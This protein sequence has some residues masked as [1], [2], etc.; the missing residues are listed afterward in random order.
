M[1]PFVRSLARSRAH[2]PARPQKAYAEWARCPH[3]LLQVLGTR[4]TRRRV[5]C[6]SRFECARVRRCGERER[7]GPGSGVA[8]PGGSRAA[9][10]VSRAH[11]CGRPRRGRV[12]GGTWSPRA[13]TLRQLSSLASL[14]NYVCPVVVVAT[15][16]ATDA[17]VRRSVRL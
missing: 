8:W 1:Q 13:A 3:C 14:G 10:T 15:G 9:F 5:P 2:A 7:I 16:P 11:A 12:C 6:G 4:D 17:I